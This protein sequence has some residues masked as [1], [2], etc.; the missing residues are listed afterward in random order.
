[1]IATFKVL[2]SITVLNLSSSSKRVSAFEKSPKT[3]PSGESRRGD[4]AGRG[5]KSTT[6]K[7]KAREK[8]W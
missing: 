7:V 8:V 5:G 3:M 4:S 2:I 6:K 1:L